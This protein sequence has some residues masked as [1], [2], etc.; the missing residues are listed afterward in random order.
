MLTCL[1]ISF[2]L[3]SQYVLNHFDDCLLIDEI[4]GVLFCDHPFVMY[5]IIRLYL[6]EYDEDQNILYFIEESAD[7]E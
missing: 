4:L 1:L 6:T 2:Q 7:Y 3:L 5:G